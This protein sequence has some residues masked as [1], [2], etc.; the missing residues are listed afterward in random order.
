MAVAP[1]FCN[2]CNL[3]IPDSIDSTIYCGDY[4]YNWG[5][6][7]NELGIAYDQLPKIY[8]PPLNDGASRDLAEAKYNT[9]SQLSFFEIV[10]L[11][12]QACD[13]PTNALPQELK[14]G[15]TVPYYNYTYSAPKIA[16]VMA[17]VVD[18]D[19]ERGHSSPPTILNMF[20]VNH[21]RELSTSARWEKFKAQQKRTPIYPS[22]NYWMYRLIFMRDY[23]WGYIDSYIRR[24]INESDSRPLIIYNTY[25]GEKRIIDWKHQIEGGG[26]GPTLEFHSG[27][28]HL[29]N[30][31]YKKIAV[32]SGGVPLGGHKFI[33]WPLNSPL[34]DKL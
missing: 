24:H 16:K 17:D 5:E 8:G 14:P 15:D 26:V 6:F 4:C 2:W 22:M 32:L 29:F 30:T 25:T 31:K 18:D 33:N 34:E 23:E 19:G 11:I 27:S 28:N 20:I 12:Q 13:N 1:I 21:I 10:N 3:E 9:I 7:G